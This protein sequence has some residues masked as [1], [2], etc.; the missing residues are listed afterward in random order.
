MINITYPGITIW[1]QRSYHLIHTLKRIVVV[2]LDIETRREDY[3][4]NMETTTTFTE[5]CNEPV[6]RKLS[7]TLA[8]KPITVGVFK[9]T[10]SIRDGQPEIMSFIEGQGNKHSIFMT[11]VHK[12]VMKTHTPI[13]GTC[14]AATWAMTTRNCELSRSIGRF[15]QCLITIVRPQPI[16]T[17]FPFFRSNS[18]MTN[19]Y[20]TVARHLQ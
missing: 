20:R 9:L 12:F 17:P 3:A 19:R 15:V 2:I 16:N 11:P 1:P 4:V 7:F 6:G 5:F 18:R 10:K 8:T 14:L 13:M